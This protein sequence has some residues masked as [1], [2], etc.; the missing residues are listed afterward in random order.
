MIV[1]ASA[2]NEG[3]EGLA[4]VSSPGNAPSAI[5]VGVS[6]NGHVFQTAVSANDPN[7]PVGIRGI[8]ATQ[9]ILIKSATPTSQQIA[10]KPLMEST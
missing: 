2:G 6:T 7:A 9:V 10:G 8:P 5:T 4:T 3:D 1:V